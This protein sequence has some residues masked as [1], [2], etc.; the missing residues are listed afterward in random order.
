[1]PVPLINYVLSE[2]VAQEAI[3]PYVWPALKVASGF[4]A[5]YAVK[6]YCRGAVNTSER[7]MHG[8]VV[9]ITVS[10]FR[11]NAEQM[12]MQKYREVPLVLELQLLASSHN[13][14][15]ISYS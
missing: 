15:P 11:P 7:N 10:V 6:W 13:E 1:M 14:A 3:L 5:L 4:G 8:K 9:M 12:L 2:G